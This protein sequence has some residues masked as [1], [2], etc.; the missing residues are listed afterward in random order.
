MKFIIL[1]FLTFTCYDIVA[2]IQIQVKTEYLGESSYRKT[3]GKTYQ[4]VGDAKGSA[5]IYQADVHIPLS[6]K[7]N[8]KNRP[9]IWSISGRFAQARLNNRNFDEPIVTDRIMN[10]GLNL[11]HLRPLNHKWSIMA[12]IGGGT[13]MPSTEFSQI[14]FKNTLG[15]IGTVFIYHLRSNLDLGVGAAIN[16][17]FGYPMLFP[18]LYLNW[19]MERKYNVEI[20]VLD[21]LEMCFRYDLNNIFRLNVIGEMNGQTALLEQDGKDKIFSH[22]YIIGGVR[23]EIKIGDNIFLN[24]TA[25]V[26]AW[27][28]SQMTERTIKSIFKKQQYYFKASPYV[29]T[30][31][32]IVL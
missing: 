8:E 4:K 6:V 17:S 13:Y 16:N 12:S 25:G 15:S 10:V 32:K 1:F 24:I 21:G 26:N 20:N 14:R 11:N 22:A 9:T 23:P 31:L 19:K 3:D 2:Q 5:V 7:L 28:P 29:A 27:R 30:Q 18:A